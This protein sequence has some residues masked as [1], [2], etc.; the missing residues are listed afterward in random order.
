MRGRKKKQEEP[1]PE[2]VEVTE[3][4]PSLSFDEFYSNKQTEMD[5]SK[6]CHPDWYMLGASASQYPMSDESMEN[7]KTA[8]KKYLKESK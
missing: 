5:F 7:P 4:V 3:E 1:L 8:Y 6:P 2:E